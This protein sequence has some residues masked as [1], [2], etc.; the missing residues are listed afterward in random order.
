MKIHLSDIRRT[1]FLCSSRLLDIP[2]SRN[3]SDTIHLRKRIGQ[4][5]REGARNGSPSVV[6]SHTRRELELEIPFIH[7][8]DSSREEA[9]L[10]GAHQQAQ[11][12]QTA[13]VMD[14]TVQRHQ[15]APE[16][17]DST[18]PEGGAMREVALQDVV[19]WDFCRQLD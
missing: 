4:Q 12:E 2:P 19:A 7:N 16:E 18:D 6:D 13:K 8:Q 9:S 14:N 17:S 10:K 5:A 3:P 15:H 1:V 11:R